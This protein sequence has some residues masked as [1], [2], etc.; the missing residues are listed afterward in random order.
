[1]KLGGVIQR[2]DRIKPNAFTEEEKTEWLNELEGRIQL[3]ILRMAGAELIRYQWPEDRETELLV[4]PPY[5]SLY[6]DYLCAM[7]DYA[8]G[9][10]DKHQNTMQVFNSGWQELAHYINVNYD[11][12]QGY[13]PE[14][15]RHRGAIL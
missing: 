6:R 11:P 13:P 1:M 2:V 14:E 15:R 9:E 5:D 4:D 10:Y 7:V 8:N 12:A 3:D